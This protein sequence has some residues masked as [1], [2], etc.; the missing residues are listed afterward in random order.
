LITENIDVFSACCA[1]LA[2][3]PS[4]DTAEGKTNVTRQFI[5]IA[6]VVMVFVLL[7]LILRVWGIQFG[8]PYA[9]HVDEP[10]YKSAALRMGVGEIGDVQATTGYYNILFVLY[11]ALY[12]LGRAAGLYPSAAAFEAAYNADWTIFYLLARLISVALGTLNIIVVY[13]L[14]REVW[15]RSVG[16]LAA[17]LLAVAFIHVRDSHFGVPD[18]TMTFLVTLAVLLT[19]LAVK[20][21]KPSY[22][23]LGAAIAGYAVAVKWTAAVLFVCGLLAIVKLA[24]A[25]SPSHR[26][27]AAMR[28]VLWAAGA[29]LV[30]FTLGGFQVF[31]RPT[32]YIEFFQ[33]EARFARSSGFNVWQIDTVPGFVFYLQTFAVGVG[34]VMLVFAVVGLVAYLVSEAR[35]QAWTAAI[36]LVFP[37]VY[38]ILMGSTQRYFVRYAEPLVPFLV[39]FAGGAIYFAATWLTRRSNRLGHLALAV[40]TLVAIAQPTANSIRFGMILMQTD[41]RTEAKEWIEQNIED[42][43]KIALDWPTLAPWLSSSVELVPSSTRS[44]DVLMVRE[45]GLSDYPLDWYRKNGYEYLV[46]TSFI[47]DL[48]APTPELMKRRQDFYASLTRTLPLLQQFQPTP[49]EAQLPFVFDE[50]YAPLVSLWERDR[51]GPTIKIYQLADNQ[52]SEDHSGSS[53]RP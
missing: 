33:R 5:R 24:T 37:L 4:H 32:A 51:P 53:A 31:I 10:M 9:Y 49:S 6:P 47:T 46:T 21:S 48:A 44:Y 36:F 23:Y 41:T 20:Y 22:L 19:V 26:L 13:W 15:N 27:T 39:I 16:V 34:L 7:G 11:A 17:L 29:C 14:G 3:P 50:I 12:V 18:V 38:F 52:N 28:Y 25:Q 1:V 35:K 45:G 2:N 40:L 42:G 30:G 8:L 43:A